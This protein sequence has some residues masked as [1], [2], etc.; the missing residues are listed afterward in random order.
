M[1]GR[2]QH[3]PL[4]ISSLLEHVARAHQSA[5]IVSLMPGTPA[6]R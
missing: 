1:L 4:L 3:H 5:E 6:H 2:M